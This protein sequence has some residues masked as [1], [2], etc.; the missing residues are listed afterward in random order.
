MSDGFFRIEFS[1]E[2]WEEIIN[3]MLAFVSNIKG[4]NIEIPGGDKNDNRNDN[5]GK[6]RV[7]KKPAK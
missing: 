2:S 3:K 5:G 1:G 7:S 4:V 6:G